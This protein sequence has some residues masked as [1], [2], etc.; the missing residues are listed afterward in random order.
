MVR[1]SGRSESGRNN[2]RQTDGS[3]LHV[4]LPK[5]SEDQWAGTLSRSPR[6]KRSGARQQYAYATQGM[7]A[8]VA[9]IYRAPQIA[10]KS[11]G[12]GI[13]RDFSLDYGV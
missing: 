4:L 8:D 7:N 5:Y 3:N 2:H 9:V 11:G 6:S 13:R 1:Q 12:N 10:H